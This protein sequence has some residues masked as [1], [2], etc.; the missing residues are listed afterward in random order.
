MAKNLSLD[1]LLISPAIFYK[2]QLMTEF[3]AHEEH[4]KRAKRS[5]RKTMHNGAAQAVRVVQNKI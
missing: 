2:H 3:I 5:I 4:E 1:S